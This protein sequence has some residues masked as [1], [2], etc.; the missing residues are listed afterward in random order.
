MK[1]PMQTRTSLAAL[2]ALSMALAACGGADTASDVDGSETVEEPA[3]DALKSI[4]DEPV[5]D[6][7][8]QN[9]DDVEAPPAVSEADAENAA[10]KA[11]LD[12][13][14]AE[15]ALAALEAELGEEAEDKADPIKE[16][17][18]ETTEIVENPDG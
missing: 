5:E 6:E 1:K 4:T 15:D 9:L 12:V 18:D 14:E 17:I 10:D 3:D 11:A 8:V 7:E 2:G 13:K 16:V